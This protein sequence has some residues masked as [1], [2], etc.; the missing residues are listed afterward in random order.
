MN[1]HRGGPIGLIFR[2]P[3][4]CLATAGSILILPSVLNIAILIILDVNGVRSCPGMF[5]WPVRPWFGFGVIQSQFSDLGALPL[6]QRE[7]PC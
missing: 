2:R 6:S 3:G 4:L 1:E 7:S 5:G